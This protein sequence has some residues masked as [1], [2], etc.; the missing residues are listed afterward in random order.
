MPDPNPRKVLTV[1]IPVELHLQLVQLKYAHGQPI[2]S[3]V[4]EALRAYFAVLESRGVASAHAE[5][6]ASGQA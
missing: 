4:E 6:Q 2:A 3:T 1:A 5:A